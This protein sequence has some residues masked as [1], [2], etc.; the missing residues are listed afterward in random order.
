MFC[1]ECGV[2]HHAGERE[3]ETAMDREVEIARI[4]AKRD[5]EV[6]RV[7][8]GMVKDEAETAAEAEVAV[9]TV[10]AEAGVEAAEA[11]A[12]VLEDV[13]SPEPAE[14]PPVVVEAPAAPAGPAEPEPAEE[15][16][17]PPVH[18]HR[19]N[20]GYGNSG[21]FSGRL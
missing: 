18:E 13:V 17:P 19:E 14:T 9:A 10:E 1:P 3:A 6:A 12:D 7:T 4:N 15:V 8:A 5:V 16:E 20:S 11:V 2:D 21:W